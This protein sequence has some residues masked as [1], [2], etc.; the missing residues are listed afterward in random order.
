MIPRM[1][2]LITGLI[3]VIL[4]SGFVIGLSQSISVG[5]A[6]FLGGLPFVII[7]AAVLCMVVYDFWDECV[8]KGDK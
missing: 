6:G 8:R 3:G 5:F 1:I 7:V 2:K 4:V